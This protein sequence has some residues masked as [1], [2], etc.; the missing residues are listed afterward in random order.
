MAGS[1][2]APHRDAA[3]IGIAGAATGKARSER[4]EQR[5]CR[6]NLRVIAEPP[7]HRA[8]ANTIVPRTRDVILPRRDRL[9]ADRAE[10]GEAEP[11]GGRN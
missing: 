9:A 6:G 4:A 1:W 2:S 10:N 3:R 7:S 8:K 5:L 11:V